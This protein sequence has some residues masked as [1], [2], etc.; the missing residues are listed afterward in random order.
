[1]ILSVSNQTFILLASIYGG[2]L[3]GLVF[4]IYRFFRNTFKFGKVTTVIGDIVFWTAG[5]ILILIIIYRS[6]SGLVRVYQLLGFSM[7][8]VAYMKLLSRHTQKLLFMFKRC[9]TGFAYAFIK[10]I[11][12]P[13][14]WASNVLWKP[15]RGAKK[16]A[17]RLLIKMKQDTQKYMLLLRKKR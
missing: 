5:L 9:I 4:D 10:V 6:S 15:C 14:V 11:R 1:M 3:L 8:M 17:G 7:G 2:L 12:G 16:A 13:A